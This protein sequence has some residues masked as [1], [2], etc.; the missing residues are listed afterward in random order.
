MT[1]KLFKSFIC[2]FFLLIGSTIQAQTVTGTVTEESTLPLP[3]VNVLVKG[4]TNGTQTD[5]DGKYTLNNVPSDATIVFSYVG[6]KTQEIAAGGQ[7]T[8]DVTLIEDASTLDEVVIIGYGSTTVR[9]A[10]GAVAAVTAEDFN[11]GVISS[12]EQLIQGK[13]AGVQITQTSGEPGAGIDIRIRGTNSVRANNNPLFVVDGVPLASDATSAGADIAGVGSNP[14]K[15]P[16]NFINPNDIES[17]SILKDASATAI[18]GARG[19]NG[20]VIITTKS[21]RSGK[22]VFEFNS[23]FSVSSVREEFDLLPADEFL[24][25]RQL[26]INPGNPDP[27]NFGSSTDWQN[28]VFRNSGSH[29]QDLSYSRSYKDGNVRATFGYSGQYGVVEKS[30]QERITGRINAQHRFLD[31]KLKLSFQGTMSRVN[32]DNPPLGATAGF[33]GDL[34]GAAYSANPTWP[35]DPNFNAGSQINPANLLANTQNET[36]TNRLLLNLSAEY[37]FTDEFSFKITG[38]YDDSVA[39]TKSVTSANA[40]LQ[41]GIPGNGRGS[42]N[43]FDFTNSL[44]EAT[45]YYNKS[46]DNSELNVVGGF[47]YQKFNRQGIN[48]S[49]WGFSTTDLNAMGDSMENAYNAVAN[50]ISGRYQQFGYGVSLLS[51]NPIG[52][53]VFINRLGSLA[54]NTPNVTDFI[55][56]ATPNLRALFVDTFDNFDE[57]QSFFLRANYSINNKYL[58]TGTVRADGSSKFGS[59]NKYGVF[60]SGAFAWKISEEDFMGDAVSTLKLRLNAGLTGNQEGIPYGAAVRN[61]RY[62][63]GGISDGGDITI[64]TVAVTGEENPDLKWESTLQYGAGIDFG[65]NNDRFNGS[66][67]VYRKETKDLI[68]FVD[69]PV[70]GNSGQQWQNLP[71]S[72]IV[73]QGFEFSLGYD[74]IQSEDLNWNFTGNISYNDN[75]VESL[76]GEYTAG[77]INGQGL[78]NAPSQRL[79]EGFPLFSWHVR[80]FQGYD[81]SGQPQFTNNGDPL[82]VDKSALP[83]LNAG[84]ST[85]VS[86]KNWT[87]NAY[88][89]GQFGHY[90]YNATANA[91]FTGG[92]FINGRNV[93]ASTLTSGESLDPS[94]PAPADVSNRFLEKGDFL[95]MQNLSLSYN[96]PLS[97][98]GTF[99]SLTLNFT[100]QNLFV[101]TDYSG[102]DP[103]VSSRTDNG[104][105]TLG[106]D[107]GAFPNPT[108]LTFGLNAKF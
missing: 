21:G 15:N 84:L 50:Q 98:E 8:I 101:I 49:G 1:Q 108:T 30:K 107:Y 13:T 75:N 23:S 88:M 40:F 61:S 99:K 46:F 93:T 53:N 28:V 56:I 74:V 58:F 5:F 19:S 35:N 42:Y 12:P 80:D 32:N 72:K 24:R 17:I 41:S 65:F 91:F 97:G 70:P 78:T 45:A 14:A 94:N 100:G 51:G 9:D 105:P 82:F 67:D 34:L 90:I 25:Q 26:L 86:Y 22:G 60:P 71:D 20:V 43:D 38:G 18:Y 27:Q 10:T 3:G 89:Y 87:L 39:E 64:P 104:L 52:G 31:D 11:Q 47:S 83:T 106:I 63:G 69:F 79:K 55:N 2:A 85:S 62:Q 44:L 68:F 81:S 92:S 102:L 7:S 73:N 33:A 76:S 16:L 77:I 4:T 48:A 95:R 57:L 103:E 96:V 29:N 36:K 37:F 59:N 54:Q 66:I 6:F